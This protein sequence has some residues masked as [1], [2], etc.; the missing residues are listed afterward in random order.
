MHF[1][2]VRGKTLAELFA[3][4]R[5]V[6]G[7]SRRTVRVSKPEHLVGMKVA[8]MASDP[9]TILQDPADVRSLPSL[10]GVDCEEVRGYFVRH[11]LKARFDD[12]IEGS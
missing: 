6:D 1:V 11:G 9:S 7:P 5:E 8:A 10:P 3:A 2:Y 12:L 4:A